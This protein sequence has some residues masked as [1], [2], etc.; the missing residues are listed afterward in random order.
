MPATTS[1]IL[2][3]G[4]KTTEAVVRANGESGLKVE[5]TDTNGRN[6]RLNAG[7]YFEPGGRGTIQMTIKDGMIDKNEQDV[8]IW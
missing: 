2:H 8:N 4:G 3:C 1:A 6:N 7:G 5:S